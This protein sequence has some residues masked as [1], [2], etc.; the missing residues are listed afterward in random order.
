MKKWISKVRKKRFDHRT[1][2]RVLFVVFLCFLDAYFTSYL[3]SLGGIEVN[4]VM[5][6]FLAFGKNVFFAAKYCITCLAIFLLLLAGE[7]IKPLFGGYDILWIVA[8]LYALVV[9][10]ELV[11]VFRIFFS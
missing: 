8:G 4:P 10:W 1:L 3:I 2:A 6:F 5:A 9:S 7:K 11:L